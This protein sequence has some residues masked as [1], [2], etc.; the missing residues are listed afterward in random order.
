MRNLSILL[1]LVACGLSTAATSS[2]TSPGPTR[3][4][5]Q[6]LD[7]ELH[8]MACN[9]SSRTILPWEVVKSPSGRPLL[10]SLEEL[11]LQ[12]SATESASTDTQLVPLYTAPYDIAGMERLARAVLC[13]RQQECSIEIADPGLF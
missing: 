2:E 13:S 10:D 3:W 6:L 7:G 5:C 4:N 9:A 1:L 8:Q 12:P 11:L